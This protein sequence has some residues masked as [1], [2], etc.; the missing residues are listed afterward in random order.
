[1]VEEIAAALPMDGEQS[2]KSFRDIVFIQSNDNEEDRR[3]KAVHYNHPLYMALAYPLLFPHGE[4]DAN[5]V[6][7]MERLECIKTHQEELCVDMYKNVQGIIAL[8]PNEGDFSRQLGDSSD[9]GQRVI[10]PST[11]LGCDHHMRMLYLNSVAIMRELG[12]PSL[13]VMFTANPKWLEILENL[14]EN[15]EAIN[16]PGL[17]AMVFHKKQQSMLHDLCTHFGTYR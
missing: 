12:K 8:D 1:M 16:D 3:L 14:A 2:E 6:V 11:H 5:S 7:E 17:L 10:L 15:S 9:I 4:T 13:F